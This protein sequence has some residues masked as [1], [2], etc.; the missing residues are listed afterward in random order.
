MM[1]KRMIVDPD[2]LSVLARKQVLSLLESERYPGIVSSHSWSTPDAN[3]RIYRL[4][5]VIAPYAGG[6]AGFVKA[7]K[8][9]KPKRDRRFYFGFGW[10]A[11]MNGFGSQGGPRVGASNPVRYPFKS[12]D[13]KV[14]LDRNR[15]G[16][17]V[18]DINVDGVAHYGLYPDWVEDL[19]MQAGDEIVEDLARGA[20]AYL[21]MWERT[22]GVPAAGTLPR[23]AALTARGLGRLR[24]GASVRQLLLA[25]GQPARRP[26]RVWT[27]RV[28]GGGR[29]VA[30]LTPRGRVAL[31]A[32]TARL[33]RAGKARP[34]DRARGTALRV[35]GRL[36]TLTR[37]GRVRAVAVGSREVVRDRA[38]LRRYLRLAGV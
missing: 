35:A 19:R 13:G 1:R 26:G 2:H 24:V 16:S 3:P 38:T 27:Y 15:S 21:Q 12:F 14:T 37:R 20:E 30:V 17:R 31:I 33:H 6:S 22:V 28:R 11:D 25:G 9:I 10:G 32:S 8:D 34:G 7:W 5:G 23:R 18:W 36:V 29:A 4:G